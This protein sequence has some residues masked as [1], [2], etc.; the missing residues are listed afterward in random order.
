MSIYLVIVRD[1]FKGGFRVSININI[2]FIAGKKNR[3]FKLAHAQCKKETFDILCNAVMEPLGERPKHICDG[4]F[5]G[6]T[7]EVKT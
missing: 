7:H 2:K 6:C 3:I 1:S 5:L 4:R